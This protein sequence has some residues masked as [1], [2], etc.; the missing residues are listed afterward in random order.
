MGVKESFLGSSRRC[1]QDQM[2][3]I[4]TRRERSSS[5]CHRYN[6]GYISL[7]RRNTKYVHIWIINEQA[8]SGSRLYNEKTNN[9]ECTWFRFHLLLSM[10]TFIPFDLIPNDT[11]I[12]TNVSY[13]A[14][15][16]VR[17][18]RVPGAL[19]RQV[20]PAHDHLPE[21]VHAMYRDPTRFGVRWVATSNQGVSN[22]VETPELVE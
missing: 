4:T 11:P 21:I 19:Q 2:E 1:T 12:A 22:D 8:A 5:S 14:N 13:V 15:H 10:I 17:P 18:G 7:T 3:S 20:C 16:R 9:R 6:Q